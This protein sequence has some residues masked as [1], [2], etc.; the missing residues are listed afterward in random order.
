L[1]EDGRSGL[2]FEVLYQDYSRV[3]AW[4]FREEGHSEPEESSDRGLYQR[5]ASIS[6]DDAIYRSSSQSVQSYATAA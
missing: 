3:L 6:K 4:L 5:M 1:G 2:G